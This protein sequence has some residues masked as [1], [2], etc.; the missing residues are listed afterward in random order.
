MF[1]YYVD[2]SN[3][4]MEKVSKIVNSKSYDNTHMIYGLIELIGNGHYEEADYILNNAVIKYENSFDMLHIGRELLLH[5][6]NLE[7]FDYLIEKEILIDTNSLLNTLLNQMKS[8]VTENHLLIF[9]KI[10]NKYNDRL[11]EIEVFKLIKT[12]INIMP[13]EIL[14]ILLKKINISKYFNVLARYFKEDIKISNL[15][16]LI[17]KYP[18]M[19]DSDVYSNVTLTKKYILAK[20]LKSIGFSTTCDEDLSP[21]DYAE[22]EKVKKDIKNNLY[23]FIDNNDIT[24]IDIYLKEDAEEVVMCIGDIINYILN[25]I[26][27]NGNKTELM[28]IYNYILENLK[29]KINK[30]YLQS[31]INYTMW[32]S[33]YNSNIERLEILKSLGVDLFHD[34]DELKSWLIINFPVDKNL[35]MYFYPDKDTDALFQIHKNSK[36]NFDYTYKNLNKEELSSISNATRIIF[37]YKYKDVKV[38]WEKHNLNINTTNEEWLMA[39]LEN[40][41]EAGNKKIIKQIVEEC[42]IDYS[43]FTEKEWLMRYILIRSLNIKPLKYLIKNNVDWMKI[44]SDITRYFLNNLRTEEIKYLLECGMNIKYFFYHSPYDD[45]FKGDY[46]ENV[47]IVLIEK[48]NYLISLGASPSSFPKD[49]INMI[50][51]FNLQNI[52]FIKTEDRSEQ[53]KWET[54]SCVDLKIRPKYAQRLKQ[55]NEEY[56]KNEFNK[57]NLN[58]ES[59]E[60]I[61]KLN[62]L[63]DSDLD[64]TFDNNILLCTA[65]EMNNIKI[66]NIL[67]N[68]NANPVDKDGRTSSYARTKSAIDISIQKHNYKLTLLFFEFLK[69]KKR[70]LKWDI[71]VIAVEKENTFV[72][73]YLISKKV[74]SDAVIIKNISWL[75]D[76]IE[77]NLLNKMIKGIK[78]EIE[79]HTYNDILTETIEYNKPILFKTFLKR[80]E[81]VNYK[82]ELIIS[83]LDSQEEKLFNILTTKYKKIPKKLLT[84]DNFELC[85]Q[86]Y[87]SCSLSILKMFF[88]NGFGLN[89]IDNEMHKIIIDNISW[90]GKL[91]TVNFLL[92]NNYDKFTK[93]DL[94]TIKKWEQDTLI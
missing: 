71:I 61:D 32:D 78:S 17:S 44:L 77:E 90:D 11:I 54:G 57:L 33:I 48:I 6:N 30:D 5:S 68:H 12:Y 64:F 40:E 85:F 56:E 84:I 28:E 14:E 39:I 45:I 86:K 36:I 70:K 23:K 38:K 25:Q 51:K 47:E 27:I 37:N 73:E 19:K 24:S 82:E 67:L 29:K 79:V 21:L 65:T 20:K 46:T 13:T 93:E 3:T 69:N 22:E 52:I 88:A 75:I 50:E 89:D 83:I 18:K 62:N 81:T 87:N 94:T 66:I 26:D 60:T 34:E 80:K 31:R 15:E 72:V 43:Y 58:S 55:E 92:E 41:R 4:L 10:F 76:N 35:L 2:H 8:E 63:L 91:E 49:I 59:K 9:Y 7:I 16:L 1:K 53:Y 74:Y 42:D